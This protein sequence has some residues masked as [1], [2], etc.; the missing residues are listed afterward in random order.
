[1]YSAWTIRK[2]YLYQ[3]VSMKKS[4]NLCVNFAACQAEKWAIHRGV[5]PSSSFLERYPQSDGK[6]AY[7]PPNTHATSTVC[8]SL[9]ITVSLCLS[10]SPCLLQPPQRGCK[11]ALW[12][13]MMNFSAHEDVFVGKC[14]GHMQAIKTGPIM[15]SHSFPLKA[16]HLADDLERASQNI[17][18]EILY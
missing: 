14:G 11:K 7:I 13:V 15:S 8:L 10:C 16:R 2:I 6:L 17:H 4:M 12:M 5:G 1:M 3:L 18:T 9:F